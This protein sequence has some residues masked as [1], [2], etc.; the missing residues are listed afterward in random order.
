M[1]ETSDIFALDGDLTGYDLTGYDLIIA[2]WNNAVTTEDLTEAQETALLGATECG[3]GVAAWHRG[4][5]PLQPRLPLP[6]RRRL[7]RAP[8]R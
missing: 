5:V 7:R 3:A 6:A 1:D 2:G 8:R 4:R